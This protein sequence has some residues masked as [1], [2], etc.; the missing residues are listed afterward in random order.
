[1]SNNIITHIT[2]QQTT[3][4]INNDRQPHTL[5]HN[6]ILSEV[7]NKFLFDLAQ[8]EDFNFFCG[9]P[10]YSKHGPIQV[11]YYTTDE[12]LHSV[13]VGRNKILRIVTCVYIPAL[14]TSS[15]DDIKFL[16]QL[17]K[18]LIGGMIQSSQ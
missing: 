3:I 16:T 4:F 9:A 13:V 7:Q 15:I 1:M 10:E 17:E 5:V 14:T 11:T 18:K 8:R 12:T 6:P 2:M